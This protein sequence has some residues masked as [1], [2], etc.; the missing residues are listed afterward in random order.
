MT[1]LQASVANG[2]AQVAAG[3]QSS[4]EQQQRELR[5]NAMLINDVNIT[6]LLEGMSK[7]EFTDVDGILGEKNGKH[8]YAVPKYV[9]AA[10]ASTHLMRTGWIDE[11]QA[12]IM[13]LEMQSMFLRMEMQFTEEEYEQGGSLILDALY[14]NVKMNIYSAVNGRISKLVKSHPHNIDVTV[15]QGNKEGF[16]R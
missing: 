14:E 4:S 13:D 8:I 9:A 7:I 11:R 1:D 3:L 2:V 5:E 6:N 15:G 12:E 16:A 10:I